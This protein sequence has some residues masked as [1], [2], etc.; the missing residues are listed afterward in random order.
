MLLLGI[1]LAPYFIKLLLHVLKNDNESKITITKTAVATS[2]LLAIGLS[3]PGFVEAKTEIVDGDA[4]TIE[5][6]TKAEVDMMSD[7]DRAN[8]KLSVC[9]EVEKNAGGTVVAQ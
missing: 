2:F 9:E 5:C 3:F 7:E 6:I 8:L 4:V 1:Q